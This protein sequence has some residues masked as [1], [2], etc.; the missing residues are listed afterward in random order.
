MFLKSKIKK[1][2]YVHWLIILSLVILFLVHIQENTVGMLILIIIVISTILFNKVDYIS[3]SDKYLSVYSYYGIRV[4][5]KTQKFKFVDIET[6]KID[7]SFKGAE[8]CDSSSPILTDIFLGGLLYDSDCL[9][10][11]KLKEDSEIVRFKL[12]VPKK[13]AQ[14]IV[15]VLIKRKGIAPACSKTTNNF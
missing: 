12:N 11:L 8:K 14:K 6:I 9:L 7:D 10:E 4:Y 1:T 2:I 15:E 3:L 5:K 13:D